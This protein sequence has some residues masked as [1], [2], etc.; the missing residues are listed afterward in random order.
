[1]RKNSKAAESSSFDEASEVSMAAKKQVELAYVDRPELSEIFADSVEK[2][3]FDGTAL[4]IEFVVNRWDEPKAQ[5]QPKGRKYPV[6]RLVLPAN[7]AVGFF[8]QLSRLFAA[9]EKSGAVKRD[10]PTGPQ[11]PETVQ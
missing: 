9:L 7:G 1:M 11:A 8:N 5:T 4:R 10:A 2:I 3:S 6:C